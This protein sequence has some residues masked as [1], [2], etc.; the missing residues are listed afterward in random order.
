MTKIKVTYECQVGY[1]K[2]FYPGVDECP[3]IMEPFV[4]YDSDYPE[5]TFNPE[6]KCCEVAQKGLKFNS[7]EKPAS[8]VHT[9]SLIKVATD[10]VIKHKDHDV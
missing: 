1:Q 10:G 3:D 4:A 2:E 9:C 8:L 7:D 6:C 5:D